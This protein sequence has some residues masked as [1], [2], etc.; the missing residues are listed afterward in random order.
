MSRVQNA[1]LIA[2][3]RSLRRGHA[4]PRTIPR[5]L[6]FVHP[7]AMSPTS[8]ATRDARP[9]S[10]L[11]GDDPWLP[12]FVGEDGGDGSVALALEEVSPRVGF[13]FR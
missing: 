8:P 2:S 12:D 3:S 4:S 9:E 10:V 13:L 6:R 1:H 11:S 7:E 5:S